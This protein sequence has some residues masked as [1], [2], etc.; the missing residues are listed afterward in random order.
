MA[1]SRQILRDHE[2]AD[3]RQNCLDL[4]VSSL[5]L[6]YVAGYGTLIGRI[7]RWLR[8]RGQLAA[9]R[10]GSPAWPRSTGPARWTRHLHVRSDAPGLRRCQRVR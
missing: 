10:T 5:A 3:S 8:P 9:T 6:H 4:V 1:E 2:S 7:G